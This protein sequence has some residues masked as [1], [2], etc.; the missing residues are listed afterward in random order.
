MKRF[1]QKI[2][3]ETRFPRCRGYLYDSAGSFMLDTEERVNVSRAG[4]F[5]Y[6]MK[7]Y[8]VSA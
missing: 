4:V 6:Y 1:V 5:M 8:I 3:V 2:E 7:V